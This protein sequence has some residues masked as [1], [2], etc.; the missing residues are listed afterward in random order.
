MLFLNLFLLLTVSTIPFPT[1]LLGRFVGTDEGGHLAGAIYGGIMVLMS[2][3]FSA[4]WRHVTRDAR[5]LGRHLDPRR[6]RQESVLFSAGL[7]AY[8]LGIGLAFVSAPLSLVL[9]ALIAIFYVFPWLPERTAAGGQ[10]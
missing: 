9:Y 2:L 7:I 10:A 3:A 8:A 4:L 6:A 1:A 5:L